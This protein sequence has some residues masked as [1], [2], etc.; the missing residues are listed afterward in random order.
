HTLLRTT[1]EPER[2][3]QPF[4]LDGQVWIVADARVDARPELI[5]ELR[6]AGHEATRDI[7]DVELILR[8]YSAWQEGC[9]DHLW[10]DFTFGV[11]DGP[12]KHLFCARD[13]MGVK[14]LFYANF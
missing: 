8:A 5:D 11:W 13:H 10:G 12:R 7:S 9:V 1:D 6:A 2:T 3:S 14:P 4:T